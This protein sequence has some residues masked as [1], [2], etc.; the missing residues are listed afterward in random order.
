MLTERQKIKIHAIEMTYLGRVTGVI[1]FDKMR[2]AEAK[3]NI[4]TKSCR[5]QTDELAR[6][7]DQLK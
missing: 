5:T 1:K 7:R 6:Q 4:H 3:D 2:S